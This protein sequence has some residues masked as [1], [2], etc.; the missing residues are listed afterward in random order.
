MAA[1]LILATLAST[2]TP[3]TATAPI[4]VAYEQLRDGDNAAAIRHLEECRDEDRNDPARLIN[5]GAAYARDGRRAEAET[6]FRAAMASDD[7]YWL[8]LAD[9]RW[10]DSRKAAR[11][12]LARLDGDRALAVR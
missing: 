4:D 7:H 12:A 5:L 1:H 3:A 6:M 9:G 10:L 2:L 8:E 11:L